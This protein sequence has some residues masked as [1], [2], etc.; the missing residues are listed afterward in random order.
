[1]IKI[2][3]IIITI[4]TF[5]RLALWLVLSV[6]SVSLSHVNAAETHRVGVAMRYTST[7]KGIYTHTRRVA[8]A[9][10]IHVYSGGNMME[11]RST[12]AYVNRSSNR[13]INYATPAV[14]TPTIQ[15]M[16]TSASAIRGGV[17]STE[18]YAQMGPAPAPRK[19]PNPGVADICTG[20]QWVQDANGDWY[21]AICGADVL[22]G[23]DC[24]NCHCNV[25][26]EG[27]W[28]VTFFSIALAIGYMII[29]KYKAQKETATQ[30]V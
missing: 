26:L 27:G 14:A 11:M 16:R 12:S 8:N 10:P 28:E 15:G 20:C 30:I 4:P 24:G 22:D 3:K 18:T 29:K 19:S 21:C 2:S 17:T 9:A 25:P 23:C 1:M 6:I 7:Y 5:L 13:G